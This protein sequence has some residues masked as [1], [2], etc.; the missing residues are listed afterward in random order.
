M[1]ADTLPNFPSSSLLSFPCNNC[2]Q[3]Q[4]AGF[5]LLLTSIATGRHPALENCCCADI[6]VGVAESHETVFVQGVSP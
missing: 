3:G 1:F 5:M 2:L 4:S 6:L